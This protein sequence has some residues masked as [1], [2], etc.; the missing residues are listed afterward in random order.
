MKLRVAGGGRRTAGGGPPSSHALGFP[1]SELQAS[2]KPY[3]QDPSCSLSLT[4]D[5]GPPPACRQLAGLGLRVLR[6]TGKLSWYLQ[7]STLRSTRSFHG[8]SCLPHPVF[9]PRLPDCPLAAQPVLFKY[10]PGAARVTLESKCLRIVSFMP[11]ASTPATV[12]VCKP[13]D[14]VLLSFVSSLHNCHLLAG[15]HIYS[16][17][18][19][20]LFMD[21]KTAPEVHNILLHEACILLSFP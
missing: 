5:S 7:P 4:A 18:S 21:A 6:S 19:G 9:L 8:L 20:K 14:R 11:F 16:F 3:D 17:L 2:A 15:Q 10:K 13:L 12:K 1:N